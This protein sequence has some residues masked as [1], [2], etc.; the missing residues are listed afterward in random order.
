MLHCRCYEIYFWYLFSDVP[1]GMPEDDFDTQRQ[2]ME[3]IRAKRRTLLA[4]LRSAIQKKKEEKL[5]QIQSKL[6]TLKRLE[7]SRQKAMLISTPANASSVTKVTSLV[8]KLSGSSN[9]L[10]EADIDPSLVTKVDE[11]DRLVNTVD[12]KSYTEP[13]DEKVLATKSHLK[14]SSYG[15]SDQTKTTPDKLNLLSE[16]VDDIILK[17][18]PVESSLV[19]TESSTSDMCN[20]GKKVLMINLFSC[21]KG[22][23]FHV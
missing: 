7:D 17:I 20:T 11:D 8:H 21:V 3:E 22:L 2:V 9:L 18:N 23:T 12:S 13:T 14:K 4:L 16:K 6:L 10:S 5:K 19:Q 1:T 15:T